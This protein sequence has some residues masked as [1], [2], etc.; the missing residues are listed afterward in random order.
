MTKERLTAKFLTVNGEERT[1][2]FTGREAQTLKALTERHAEGITPLEMQP[3]LMRLSAYVK[4]LRDAGIEIET[5]K[6]RSENGST[7]GRYFLRTNVS[8]PEY[9]AA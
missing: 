1:V 8:I 2:N 5:V 4:N 9:V 6:A 3:K 7:Y